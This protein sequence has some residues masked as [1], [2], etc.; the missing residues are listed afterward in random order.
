MKNQS[1]K[2]KQHGFLFSLVKR[3]VKLF[4]KKPTIYSEV[5]HYESKAIFI[6]NHSA[7][8]GPMVLSLYFPSPFVPW[9][10]HPMTEGYKKRWQYLYYI[11]YQQKLGYKKFRSFI[12]AT[13]FALISKMLYK[14]MR[15][16]PTYSNL[17][18]SKTFKLS[19]QCIDSDCPILVFPEDSEKGYFEVLTKYNQGFIRFAQ[20]YYKKTNIDLPIYTIYFSKQLNA[21]IIEKPAFIQPLLKTMTSIEISDFFKD[22]TNALGKRLN[23]LV[24]A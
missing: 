24:K 6:S 7:A 21:M 13:L 15:L 22:K 2:W 14:G 16:I 9:G 17:Q 18:L 5:S 3:V 11:F 10:A 23:E 8:S 19:K 1:T 20:Y 12:I 4:K